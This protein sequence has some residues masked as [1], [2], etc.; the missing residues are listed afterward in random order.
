MERLWI[1]VCILLGVTACGSKESEPSTPDT[2]TSVLAFPGADGGGRYTTGGRGT[3]IHVIYSL[4]DNQED[5]EPG[6][7]RYALEKAS[8]PRVIVFNVGGRID[9]EFPITVKRG[10][11]TILGQTAPGDGIC[12][13]GFPVVISADDVIMRY[14]R[15][16]MG[17]LKKAEG[18]ALTIEKGHK[19]II[20][21]HCSFSWS[22]D[23]CVS[24]YGVENFTLQYCFITESLNSSVHAKGA[25]GYGG[26]WG[27]KNATFHHNLLAHHSSRNPRFDH[28]YVTNVNV[29]PVD[30]INNVVF[31]WGGNSAYGGESSSTNGNQR[32]YNFINNYYKPGPAT[33]S[34][35]KTRLLNPTTKCDDYC[36]KTYGGSVVPGLFYVTG[37]I[38]DG[39]D[40]VTN[41]NW[42][43]VYP[44]EASKK[45]ACKS[46]ARFTYTNAYVAEQSAQEAY[47]EVLA[48][49]GCS[50]NRD[51]VDLRIVEDVRN[52][53]IR[54]GAVVTASTVTGSNGSKGGLI[55]TPDDVRGWPT[56]SGNTT[57]SDYDGIP[58]AWE[59]AHGLNP[60]DRKD[61][62]LQTLQAP[63][64]NIEVY[65]NDLVKDL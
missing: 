47:E 33:K 10:Q 49:G 18:D 38:M 51:A 45:S 42:Q 30:Y 3:S 4:E 23:E 39:S 12:V 48:K 15:F 24:V 1:L 44:D 29:A 16:R 61:A 22:T 57:D 36:V 60:K 43:G 54:N 58:D 62:A 50:F 59:T 17:D 55:D 53:I 6:T 65:A 28:D 35:V 52:G 34:N 25:H 9:L 31:N 46:S 63:Y 32:Q 8:G 11:V 41:D 19:N 56:Y 64:M 2:P 7:L 40:E 26:I 13:S 21:D 20:I 14:M 27:G 37:N 5:P